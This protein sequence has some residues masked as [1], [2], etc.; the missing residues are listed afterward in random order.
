MDSDSV[1]ALKK[2]VAAH[3]EAAAGGDEGAVGIVDAA[4]QVL[5]IHK[6]LNASVPTR[7]RAV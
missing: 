1:V 4:N 6:S 3:T 7:A 5:A 2:I